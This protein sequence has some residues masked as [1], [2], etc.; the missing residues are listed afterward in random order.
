MNNPRGVALLSRARKTALRG[1][2]V[3]LRRR[4]VTFLAVMALL[5][6]GIIGAVGS[7]TADPR[8]PPAPPAPPKVLAT[9]DGRVHYLDLWSDRGAHIALDEPNGQGFRQQLPTGSSILYAT[10]VPVEAYDGSLRIVATGTNGSLW[11]E[12][13]RRD[14]MPATRDGDRLRTRP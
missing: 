3:R 13:H 8:T 2:R 12:G 4:P 1:R 10:S 5:A 11:T 6:A 9:S 14:P 7:S